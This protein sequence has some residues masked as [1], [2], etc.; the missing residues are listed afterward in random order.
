ML[1]CMRLLSHIYDPKVLSQGTPMRKD[2]ALAL[3][4]CVLCTVTGF[5]VHMHLV[6]NWQQLCNQ[7]VFLLSKH[8]EAKL[9]M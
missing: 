8:V 3:V 5:P 6:T 1:M 7:F 4:M 2:T 9:N